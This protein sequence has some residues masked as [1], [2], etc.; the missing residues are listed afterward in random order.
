MDV[1][2]NEK[3]V[4]MDNTAVNPEVYTRKLGYDRLRQYNRFHNKVYAKI[5]ENK[6]NINLVEE[7]NINVN[8]LLENKKK[9]FGQEKEKFL[10]VLIR[11]IG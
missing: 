5:K 3:I 9:K 4:I 11:F 10:V 6:G 8:V 7:N 2:E 1:L